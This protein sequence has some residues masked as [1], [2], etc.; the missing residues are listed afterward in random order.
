MG[1]PTPLFHMALGTAK[2]KST[3]NV[4]L[5]RVGNRPETMQNAVDANVE[6]SRR[7]ASCRRT[8]KTEYANRIT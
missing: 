7:P 6:A 5:P 2:C 4:P 1:C 3:G 8:G